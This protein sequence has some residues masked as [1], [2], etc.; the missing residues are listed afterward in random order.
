MVENANSR[1]PIPVA[2]PGTMGLNTGPLPSLVDEQPTTSTAFAATVSHPSTPSASSPSS[3][4]LPPATTTSSPPA[5]SARK[6]DVPLPQSHHGNLG[7]NY[8]PP[9][10]DPQREDERCFLEKDWE[11]IQALSGECLLNNAMHNTTAANFL[12]YEGLQRLIREKEELTSARDQ[13]LAEREQT[14][15][16]LSELEVKV[17]EVVAQG[18][19]LLRVQFDEAKAKWAKVHSVVLVASEREA[20]TVERLTNLEATLISKAEELAVAGVKYAQLEEKY[21]RTIEHNRLFSSTVR[22]LDVSLRSVRF[23]WENLSAKAKA[24]VVDFDAEIAKTHEL[25]LAAKRGLPARPNATD[26]SS[27]DFEFSGTEEEPEGD[28]GEGK[29][30]EGQDIEPAAD[31]STSPGRADA[32]LPPRSGDAAV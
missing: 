6:E 5:A 12:D 31:L 13:L 8:A 22:D 30:D 4:T 28:D 32:S 10:E 16:R 20:A 2:T 7:Q 23:A 17:A 11:K 25:E 9:S 15:A 3:P 26:S 21:R 1:C 18:I 29:N 24:G 14:I 19:G 27:S